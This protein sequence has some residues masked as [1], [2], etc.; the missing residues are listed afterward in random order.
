M[1]KI[2]IEISPLTFSKIIDWTSSNTEREVGGYLIGIVENG[3]VKIIETTFAVK[4]STPTHVTIDEMAQFRIIKEIE[5]RNGKE[6]IVGFWHTHPGMGCFL[7]GTDI[8]TQKIYQALLPEAVAMV[9]DGNVFAQTR[10]QKDF[11]AHFYRVGKESKY[12]EVSFGV[13][14]NPNELL[15]LLTDYVQA[16]TNVENI[17]TSTVQHMSLNVKDF[18]EI[19]AEDKLV[20]KKAFDDESTLIKKAIAQIRKDVE[21]KHA[22]LEE[23]LKGDS[24]KL[25]KNTR[26]LSLGTLISLVF[27][28]L[29][30]AGIITLIILNYLP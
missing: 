27:S 10:D 6:T 15:D 2:N 28:L 22:N 9:N 5:K 25:N 20:T 29:S 26:I 21:S 11:K 30:L 7:S 17:V 8:A 12:H 14:T 4:N 24:L 16:E 3:N 19:V 23:Q 13:I 1:S 18:I